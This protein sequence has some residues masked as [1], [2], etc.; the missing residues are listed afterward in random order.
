MTGMARPVA[1]L[2]AS[3]GRPR[4]GY[5]PFFQTPRRAS[6]GADKLQRF[7][8]GT[9]G[10]GGVRVSADGV[11]VLL[12]DRGAADH[13]LDRVSQTRGIDRRNDVLHLPSS[14]W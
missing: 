7:L 10:V 9:R 14:S 13:H 8:G 4:R 2:H 1:V 3:P 6:G 5:C 11:A 12:R